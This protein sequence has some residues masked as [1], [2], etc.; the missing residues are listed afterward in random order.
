ME[1]QLLIVVVLKSL[2]ELAGMFLLGQGVLYVLAGGKRD[3]N[4]IYQLF[5]LLTSPVTR[6]ARLITPRVVIDRHIPF[7]AVVLLAW[8]WIALVFAKAQ[9]CAGEGVQCVPRDAA[10]QATPVSTRMR[11]A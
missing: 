10:A 3:T 9:I 1:T 11:S 5:R 6:A 4:G 7:V 8:I 2:V